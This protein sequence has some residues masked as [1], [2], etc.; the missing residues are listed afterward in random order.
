MLSCIDRKG[1]QGT[2]DDDDDSGGGGDDDDDDDDGCGGGGDGGDDDDGGGGGGDNND[3]D[4]DNDDDDDDDDDD[5]CGGG[6]DNNDNDDDNND[7]DD[8]S[9][10][11]C[12]YLQLS[13]FQSTAHASK[14][15]PLLLSARIEVSVWCGRA[16]R[17][18]KHHLLANVFDAVFCRCSGRIFKIKW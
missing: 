5:G 10:S 3:N 16:G 17:S 9:T 4:D 1:S 6:G 18:P 8:M 11:P 15:Q 14:I 7:D 13:C 12:C 2:C